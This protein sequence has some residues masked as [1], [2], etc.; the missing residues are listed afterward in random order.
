M[1][2]DRTMVFGKGVVHH[3]VTR[4][5]GHLCPLVDPCGTRYVLLYHGSDL[6]VPR[7]R[8]RD[9]YRTPGGPSHHLVA[10]HPVRNRR[11]PAQCDPGLG[12]RVAPLLLTPGPGGGRR[13]LETVIAAIG[14][15]PDVQTST[16]VQ[17][18][19]SPGAL[20]RGHRLH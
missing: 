10:V 5:G 18:A 16:C 12:V 2:I 11:R 19:A 20:T 17:A 13:L 6:D 15:V 1:P 4:A 3:L 8:R 7:Y 9:W 14:F